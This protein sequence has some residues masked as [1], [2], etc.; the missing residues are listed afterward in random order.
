MFA[1]CDGSVTFLAET[2]EHRHVNGNHNGVNN[3]VYQR[4]LSRDDGL[5]VEQP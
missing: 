2:V 4:L 5:P 3:G 1:R